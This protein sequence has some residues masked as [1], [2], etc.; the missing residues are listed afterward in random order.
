MQEA[1]VGV[2][3]GI[4]VGVGVGV[5][6]MH[7]VEGQRLR[8]AFRHAPTF[9]PVSDEVPTPGSKHKAAC[10]RPKLPSAD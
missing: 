6:A 7:P 8:F 4:G 1:G 9:T 2:G 5:T 3:V 10:S